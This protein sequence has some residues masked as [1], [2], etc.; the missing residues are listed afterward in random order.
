MKKFLLGTL[1]ATLM[2]STSVFADD[3]GK[4]TATP[5]LISAPIGQP[6]IESP[7]V[8]KTTELATVKVTPDM[9]TARVSI[10]NRAKTAAEAK[11]LND[12]AIKEVSKNLI[13]AGY[14]TEKEI[15]T[16]DFYIYP[17]YKYN[18]ATGEQTQDGYNAEASLSITVKDLSNLNK[19][20]DKVLETPSTSI[21]YTS[22]ETSKYEEYYNEALVKAIKKAQSRADYVAKTLFDGSKAEISEISTFGSNTYYATESMAGANYKTSDSINYV[23]NTIDVTAQAELKFTIK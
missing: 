3:L 1:A 11:A 23:P 21:S 14:A 8:F 4:G 20:F 15:S 22:F 18:E 17:Y 19:V 5:V 7:Q 12:K 2:L 13:S 16:T 6:V 10:S 9:A